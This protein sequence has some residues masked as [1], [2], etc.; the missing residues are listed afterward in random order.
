MNAA[1]NDKIKGTLFGNAIGDALGLG[2]EFMSRE[3]VSRYYPDGLR[4]YEQIVRDVHRCRWEPGAWTDDTDMMLCIAEAIIEDGAVVPHTVA[5]HFK[6]WFN[7]NP[8]GIGRNTYNVL[9]MGDYTSNPAKAARLVWEMSGRRSAANGGLMRTSVVGLWYEDVERYAE[10]ICALTHADPRC[11]GS[12]VILSK[13]VH[14]LAYRNELLSLEKLIE[15][16]KR[17]DGR[18]EEYVR[19]VDCR[20]LDE[21]CLDDEAMGYTLKTLSAALWCLYHSK[22][23]EEGLLAIVN[24]GGDADT[25]GAVVCSLLGAR[26]GYGAIPAC[27]TDG[28]RGKE[29]L[30]WVTEKLEQII[31]QEIA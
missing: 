31:G 25:N 23:F 24:A 13:L 12:C 28:L 14:A 11:I 2:T 16:G 18:I 27:Y 4:T 26:F 10:E 17:Y 20:S 1:L 22:T 21:L 7:G 8:M 5:R 30:V 9:A 3:E 6:E 15:T 29:R 19:M